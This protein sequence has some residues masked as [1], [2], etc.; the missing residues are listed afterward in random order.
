MSQPSDHV[1]ELVTGRWRSQTVYAGVE[2][3]VFEA[4]EKRPKHAVE[5]ADELNIDEEKGYRLLRALS[6][7]DLLDES[8]NRRFSITPA[9]ALLQE[10]HP[11]SLRGF[12]LLEEGP[13][14]YAT[15]KHLPE[16]VRE[17]NPNGFQREFGHDWLEHMEA[18]PEYA[19]MF[20]EAMSSLSQNE[21]A[22]VADLLD[23]IKFS[24]FDHV[25]DVGG[26]HGHL[27][28]TLIRDTPSVEG[29]VLELPNVVEDEAQ[30]WHE[31][32]GLTDRV[33]FVEGDFFEDV[34][35]A[36][37][38]LLKHILHDWDDSECVEILSTIR[39]AA[40]DD[41]RLFNCEFVVPEPD[42]SH[43]A[44]LFDVHMMV[45][46]NGRERTEKEHVELFEAAGFEHVETHRSEEVPLATVEGRITDANDS[47]PRGS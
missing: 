35:G 39:E 41:A 27:L 9:G 11:G 21:S 44:K 12:A 16:I 24:E 8:A 37:V 23:G 29:S 20:N 34:P 30:H 26:G 18:D 45:A 15:W 33:R 47:R 40:P 22:M 31:P 7:L 4:V 2:L 32:M 14:H 5:I 10:N 25:C 28:C 36:D 19:Q 1:M 3:G 17:G 46:T 43:L 38:Y 6:S 42:Q 13:T